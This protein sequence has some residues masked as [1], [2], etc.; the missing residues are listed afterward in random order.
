VPEFTRAQQVASFMSK[1]KI[2]D[3]PD[4]CWEWTACTYNCG[5]GSFKWKGKMVGAN[6][7]SWEIANGQDIPEGMDVLHSCDNPICVNPLHLRIGT[8]SENMIEMHQKLR[9]TRDSL[10]PDEVREIRAAFK[11]WKRG[12]NKE[13]AL[14]YGVSGGVI[15][16]I[17]RGRTYR[18]VQSTS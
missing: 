17:K 7:V 6:R 15:S 4:H 5:Y 10:T 13:L 3:N 11:D 16:A 1:V 2:P 14:R 8:H 18:H 9:C 12:T